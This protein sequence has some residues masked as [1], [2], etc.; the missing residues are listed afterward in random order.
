MVQPLLK[1]YRDVFTSLPG[2]LPM[3]RGIAH[4]IPLEEGVK[5]P[6]RPMYR[7]SPSE[8]TEMKC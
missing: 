8:L 2:G 6:F 5:P 3:D 4:A 7:L 1:E